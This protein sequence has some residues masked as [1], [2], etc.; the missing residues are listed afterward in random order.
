MPNVVEIAP[1]HVV[2]GNCFQCY[3]VSDKTELEKMTTFPTTG[4]HKIIEYQTK[5]DSL[6]KLVE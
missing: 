1:E 6:A 4:N 3:V 5:N 2:C